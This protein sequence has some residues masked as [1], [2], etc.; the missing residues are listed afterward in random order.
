M[1]G[2]DL[3]APGIPRPSVRHP[4]AAC[5]PVRSAGRR[6]CVRRRA[7]IHAAARPRRKWRRRQRHRHHPWSRACRLAADCHQR[8]CR[9]R[10]RRRIRQKGTPSEQG[11]QRRGA[12]PRPA[13]HFAVMLVAKLHVLNPVHRSAHA[14]RR[15]RPQ[16]SQVP[17]A[18]FPLRFFIQSG[19]SAIICVSDGVR[20][21]P[22]PFFSPWTQLPADRA[23]P[24]SRV[25]GDPAR[26]ARAAPGWLRE[27]RGCA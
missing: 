21:R 23:R 16:I 25:A 17:F 10:S 14:R 3:A 5:C 20:Q 19:L 22:L 11:L 8:G 6:W 15:R 24:V 26:I 4:A 7:A 1:F 18:I 9:N 13:R 27:A 2:I 12:A